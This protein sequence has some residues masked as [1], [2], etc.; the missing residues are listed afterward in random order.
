VKAV[1]LE[2]S[3]LL[4]WLL[5]EAR[6]PEVARA[7]DEADMVVSSVLTLVEAE[8]ALVRAEI[9]NILNAADAERLRGLLSRSRQGWTLMEISADVRVRACR[10]FP[11]EPL[12]T[13]EALHLA[14]ALLFM[15]A[16]PS[17]KLLSCD[18]RMLRNARAL[19]LATNDGLHSKN[20]SFDHS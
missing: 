17:L 20:S 16:F 13:L 8:R 12:R 7:I 15:Q 4:A 11:V 1:Y 9:L 19:G 5:G 6:A 2:T 14:T 18:Q 3:A 10:F